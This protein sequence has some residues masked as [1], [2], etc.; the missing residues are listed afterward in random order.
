[1]ARRRTPRVLGAASGSD[2]LASGV[3]SS[4]TIS[5]TPDRQSAI[6]ITIDLP[7]PPSVNAIW[8]SGRG[9]VYRSEKYLDWTAAADALVMA[10]RQYPKRK[11]GGHFSA[12][13]CLSE[14]HGRGDL[15]NKI[16]AVLDWAQSRDL[17]RNDKDCRRLTAEYAAV[18][19]CR[20]ILRTI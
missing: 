10:N 20:L 15:D 9:R 2:D 18:D 19:G 13:I 16:K 5:Q 11:I 14:D 7:I 8:R 3:I 12:H 17:I 4:G 6:E 1:M